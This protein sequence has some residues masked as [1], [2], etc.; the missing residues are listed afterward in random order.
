M[1][2]WRFTTAVFDELLPQTRQ[3]ER[4]KAKLLSRLHMSEVFASTS[5]PQHQRSESHLRAGIRL[6][7]SWLLNRGVLS[8]VGRSVLKRDG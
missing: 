3:L 1:R 4:L 8:I 6:D 7:P 2:R 5:Q